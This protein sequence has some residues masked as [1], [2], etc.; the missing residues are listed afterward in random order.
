MSG[1]FELQ[2]QYRFEAAHQLPK[3]PASHPCHALHGHSYC[4]GVVVVGRA[5][6]DTGWVIDFA[7]IDAA[8]EP[9]RAQV[10]HRL[11]NEVAGLENPTSEVLARWLWDRLTGAL[12]GLAAVSVA[13]TPDSACTYRGV[14]P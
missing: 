9:L 3:V 10:D 6:Q 2:R 1:V 11:L 5:G 8:F 12:P 14:G 4:V 13:E 7:D